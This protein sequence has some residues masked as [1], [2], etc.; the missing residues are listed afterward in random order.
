MRD[1][2]EI[3]RV[4]N[5]TVSMPSGVSATMQKKEAIPLLVMRDGT[6]YWLALKLKTG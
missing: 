4:G 1:G 2:D 5:G 3:V 6:T